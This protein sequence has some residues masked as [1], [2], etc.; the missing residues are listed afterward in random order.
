MRGWNFKF[1]VGR[2]WT[3]E[4]VDWSLVNTGRPPFSV[5]PEKAP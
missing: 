2:L 3:M 1:I 5:F 4:G